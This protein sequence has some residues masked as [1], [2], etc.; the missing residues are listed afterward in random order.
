[1]DEALEDEL[2]EQERQYER[3][4][5]RRDHDPRPRCQLCSTPLLEDGRCPNS[6]SLADLAVEPD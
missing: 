4:I 3:G 6:C 1:M 5:A 2:Y